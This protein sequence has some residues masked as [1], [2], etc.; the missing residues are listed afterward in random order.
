[1]KTTNIRET[2]C[3]KTKALFRLSYMTWP[4]NRSGLFYQDNKHQDQDQSSEI[5][6]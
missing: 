5:L 6:S 4:G 2:K 3:N 1:V